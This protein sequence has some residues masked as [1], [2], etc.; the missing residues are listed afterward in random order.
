MLYYL[1]NLVVYLT[2]TFTKN[3]SFLNRFFIDFIKVDAGVFELSRVSLI[4]V[5]IAFMAFAILTLEMPLIFKKIPIFDFLLLWGGY[6]TTAVMAFSPTI[7]VSGMRTRYLMGVLMVVAIF[8]LVAAFSED[9]RI[10]K[11]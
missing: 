7:Y 3:V 11:V 9:R 6:C 8:H 4:C 2:K 1:L 10:V 5:F